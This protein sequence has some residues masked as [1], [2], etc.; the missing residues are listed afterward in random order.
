[1]VV[2]A[3][4]DPSLQL[5]AIERSRDK[6]LMKRVLVVVALLANGVQPCDEV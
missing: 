6:P 3:I 2:V 4:R 5:G 1:L